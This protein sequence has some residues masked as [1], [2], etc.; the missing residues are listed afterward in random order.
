MVMRIRYAHKGVHVCCS[1]FTAPSYD[2]TYAY[3]GNLI[4]SEFEWPAVHGM[5]QGAGAELVEVT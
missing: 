3:C 1:V 2:G 4:F 5:F